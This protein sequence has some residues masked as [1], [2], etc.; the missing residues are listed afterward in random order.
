MTLRQLTAAAAAAAFASACASITLTGADGADGADGPDYRSDAAAQ[1][2]AAEILRLPYG[3]PR[4]VAEDHAGLGY[5]AGF[6]AAQDNLCLV[7]ERALTV[8]GERA[9]FLGAGEDDANIARGRSRLSGTRKRRCGW[10][11]T[12]LS[13]KTSGPSRSSTSKSA[14]SSSARWRAMRWMIT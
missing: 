9:A 2:Y 3:V 4:I 5:G 1:T 6:V 8:R 14:T 13:G 11:C 12:S 10:T 7:M